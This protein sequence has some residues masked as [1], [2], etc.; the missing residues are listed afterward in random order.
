MS[1]RTCNRALIVSLYHFEQATLH[2]GVSS[3][4]CTYGYN[5]GTTLI[6]VPTRPP[7]L[8]PSGYEPSA[9]LAMPVRVTREVEGKADQPIAVAVAYDKKGQ[10]V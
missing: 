3:Y 9:L 10:R 5:V 8:S 1:T 2:P 4:V 6:S 7:I